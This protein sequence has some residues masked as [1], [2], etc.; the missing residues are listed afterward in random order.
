MKEMREDIGES[1]GIV[2]ERYGEVMTKLHPHG[3]ENEA[4][5]R[6]KR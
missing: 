4:A 5:T 2:E 6:K 1:W 3:I